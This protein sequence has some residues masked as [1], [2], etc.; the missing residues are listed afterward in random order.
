MTPSL[1]IPAA[2]SHADMSR[3]V[4]VQ[5]RRASRASEIKPVLRSSAD[6]ILLFAGVNV[7]ARK[8]LG[9]PGQ[10]LLG[11][12]IPI[13]FRRPGTGSSWRRNPRLP[14]TSYTYAP[15]EGLEHL[16]FEPFN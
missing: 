9:Q 13:G 2:I 11:R 8:I 12:H 10:K 7:A 14:A 5:S 3:T 4:R 6:A 15:P 1:K 16:R